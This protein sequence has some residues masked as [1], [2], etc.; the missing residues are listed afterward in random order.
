MARG[1]LY[2]DGTCDC[3][4]QHLIMGLVDRYSGVQGTN[5]PDPTSMEGMVTSGFEAC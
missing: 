3:I 5:P 4:A 2:A 1:S